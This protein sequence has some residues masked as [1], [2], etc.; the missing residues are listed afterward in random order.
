MF[1]YL[2]IINVPLS[3]EHCASLDCFSDIFLTYLMNTL[4]RNL[5]ELAL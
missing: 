1:L 2:R 5:S 3:K 4:N